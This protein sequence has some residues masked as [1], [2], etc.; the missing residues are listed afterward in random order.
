M[1]FRTPERPIRDEDIELGSLITIETEKS[2]LEYMVI[3]H[4]K[5]K[6]NKPILFGLKIGQK[7]RY[8][9]FAYYL[10]AD[11]VVLMNR[12]H[13]IN[14]ED[15]LIV[16]ARLANDI[17][18][19]IVQKSE[20]QEKKNAERKKERK[21]ALKKKISMQNKQKKHTMT[22]HPEAGTNTAW[23]SLKYASKGYI[24]IYRG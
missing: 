10:Y 24:H 20:K 17:V 11:K 14:I 12:R 9:K 5:S 21:K 6:H 8:K 19:D 2:T 23:N 13:Q 7:D 18:D 22:Y 3:S 1:I 4:Q 16:K 15:I